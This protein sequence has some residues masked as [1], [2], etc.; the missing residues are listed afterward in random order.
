MTEL[1]H[2]FTGTGYSAVFQSHGDFMVAVNITTGTNSIT[3]EEEI[4]GEGVW[5]ILATYTANTI[6]N[7]ERFAGGRFR[8]NCGTFDTGPV[9]CTAKGRELSG[10]SGFSGGPIYELY[11]LLDHNGDEI[12]DSNGARITASPL[13][14]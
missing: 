7:F 10:T 8:W 11:D 14:A 13:A 5:Q 9:R 2:I 6:A 4:G 3:L 12:L 1:V